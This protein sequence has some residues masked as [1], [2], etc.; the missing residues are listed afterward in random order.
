MVSIIIYPL[1]PHGVEGEGLGVGMP[2]PG[3]EG[4][5]RLLPKPRCALVCGDGDPWHFH[6]LQDLKMWGV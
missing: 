1:L 4:I 3:R 5:L 6:P 2:G